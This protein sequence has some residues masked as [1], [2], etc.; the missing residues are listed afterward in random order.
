MAGY[1]KIR[2]RKKD[3]IT[4][5]KE[6]KRFNDKVRYYQRK[7]AR[8]EDRK[9]RKRMIDA[10][11]EKLSV[12]ELRRGGVDEYGE[13]QGPI[14]R[15]RKGFDKE[16]ESMRA[17][18]DNRGI[19]IVDVPGN[20]KGV[21]ITEWQL[22]DMLAREK[23]ANRKRKIRRTKV[24]KT[25]VTSRGKKVGYTVGMGKAKD[26][27]LNNINAF[28]PSQ[29]HT[30]IKQKMRTLRKESQPEYWVAKDERWRE[31]Y[32]RTLLEELGDTPEVRRIVD[33]INSLD[34][35]QFRLVMHS[36]NGIKEY[37]YPPDIEKKKEAINELRAIWLNDA[38]VIN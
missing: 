34:Y 2:W 28:T 22:N 3:E 19:N 11:P 17:F 27:N 29:T 35:K 13:V 33:H 31:D 18:T 12:K 20:E 14:I 38:D 32:T 36:E 5:A 9:E 4:L 21:A 1:S 10:L 25:E 15:T 7:Y 30:D 8:I 16:I 23:S 26:K 24:E 6:V 37:S